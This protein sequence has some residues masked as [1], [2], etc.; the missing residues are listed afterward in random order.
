M[1]YLKKQV[2]K[3]HRYVA[4]SWE[5]KGEQM[6]YRKTLIL[7]F[8]LTKPL[9][10]LIAYIS[11]DKKYI[12]GRWFEERRTGWVWVLR[13]LWVQKILRFNSSSPFPI[14]ATTTVSNYNNLIFHPDDLN[15]MQ[16]SGCYFQNF[17]AKIF[18]GRGFYIAPNVGI[19]TAN[20]DPYNLDKHLEGKDVIIGEKC[21]IGMNSV[22]LP[23]VLLGD[24]TIVAAGSVVNSSFPEGHCVIGGVPAKFIKHL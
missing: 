2:W 24:S 8:R 5:R 15:N 18:I 3:V 7:V 17:K 11:F 23:G 4:K 14:N 12:K 10:R 21:W 1:G 20:H 22:I 19:I 6:L 9:I 13:A 16:S